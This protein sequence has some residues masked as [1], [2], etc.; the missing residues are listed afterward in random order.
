MREVPLAGFSWLCILLVSV[1]LHEF[2]CRPVFFQKYRKE[3]QEIRQRRLENKA[4][5]V[6][7][8]DLRRKY[9]SRVRSES[10]ASKEGIKMDHPNRSKWIKKDKEYEKIEANIR[11]H[12]LSAKLLKG[13]PEISHAL[14]QRAKDLQA[15]SLEL[16]K[17]KDKLKK[18][19]IEDSISYTL[20][21]DEDRKKYRKFKRK[22][23]E[24]HEIIYRNTVY[25]SE[26]EKG[27]NRCTIL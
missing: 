19:G 13:N 22:A 11:R 8:S 4:A 21:S 27:Q 6:R 16:Q 1:F 12:S 20:N 10:K 14:L 25:L 3:Q 26:I 2:D 9:R 17:E 18:E 24:C 23:N 7:L 5:G 15:P